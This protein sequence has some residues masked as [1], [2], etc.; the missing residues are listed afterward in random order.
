[1]NRLVLILVGGLVLLW[2]FALGTHQKNRVFTVDRLDAVQQYM[3]RQA[4]KRW[5]ILGA[6]VFVAFLGVYWGIFAEVPHDYADIREHFKYGS[7]GSDSGAGIPYRIWWVLPDLFPHHLPDP[8]RYTSLP[9]TQR[10][11]PAAYAQFGFVYE[12]GHDLPIGFTTRKVTVDRIGLNCA[13]C[14][15]ATIKVTEGM[16]PTR[17]YGSEPGYT[18]SK[19]VRA[20]VL[21]M[22][23]ITVDLG[24]YLAFLFQCAN[25]SE[26]TT[27][28]VLAAIDKRYRLGPIDRLLYKRAVPEVQKALAVQGKD[29]AF[30]RDNP[31]A[32][33]GR[34]D[35]FNPY[36][37][38]VFKFPPDGSIGTSDFPSIWNQRP[39]EGMQLHWDGNNKSVFERN[40]SASLGAGATPVSLDM[41]RMLRVAAWLGAPDP[42]R[43]L[44]ED[45]I[46]EA[47]ADPRPQPGELPIPRFPF[48]IDDALAARGGAVYARQCAACH[49]WQGKYIG[50]TEPIDKIGTD[51]SRLDS[52]TTELAANQNTLGAGHW[53]R[54][55]HFRKTDGYV[56]MPLDGLWARAPYLH[57]GSVPTLHDLLA[58]P[59]ERPKK[60]FRGDDEYDPL[61]VGFRSNR[62]R[63]D[64]GRNLF[65]FR[66]DL[67]GNHNSGHD[68]G[69]ALSE[70]E[71]KALLEYLK[72]L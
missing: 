2:S 24:A 3:R 18:S 38:H 19:K 8:D 36:K 57:N 31:P 64:D 67:P 33:P 68:Y 4:C 32:G 25:D 56:C 21:G 60:F 39:R 59:A 45:E 55:H 65:E 40:I 58:K 1:M 41:P 72:T 44:T 50:Q 29:F 51:R 35:T 9:D 70:D 20:I 6:L 23:A 11:A 14:H 69:T 7:I 42:H 52:F 22:P 16:D 12:E 63:S 49:D 53:W 30:L 26:F 34:V 5:L 62:P 15:V 17:I 43:E 10:N 47:R 13:V 61:K 66:T 54:F 46:H 27:D 48:A 37:N 71:K 28:N